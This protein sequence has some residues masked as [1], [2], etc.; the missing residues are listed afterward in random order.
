VESEAGAA[1]SQ[2]LERPLKPAY[3]GV[4]NGRRDDVRGENCHFSRQIRH[5]PTCIGVPAPF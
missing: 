5:F 4:G 2:G 1:G 3:M